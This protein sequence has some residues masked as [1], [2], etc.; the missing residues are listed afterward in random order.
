MKPINENEYK[1]FVVDIKER[2][3]NAQYRALKK[4]NKEL[5]TLYWDIGKMIVEKQE[6][7]GWGKAVVKQLPIDINRVVK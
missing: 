5:I 1:R 4:V 2:I 6:E 7:L 3:Q